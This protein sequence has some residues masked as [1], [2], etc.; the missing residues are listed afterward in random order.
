[1]SCLDL[2]YSVKWKRR[3]EFKDETKDETSPVILH[4]LVEEVE[5]TTE[6]PL[7]RLNSDSSAVSQSI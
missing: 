4:D 7:A 3:T 5:E 1:M 6:G 2:W